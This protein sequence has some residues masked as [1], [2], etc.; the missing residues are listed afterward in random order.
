ME[1]HARYMN[2][3]YKI[4]ITHTRPHFSSFQQSQ[5]CYAI[6]RY[7]PQGSYI[8]A[9]SP[10]M[11]AT[12]SS[13]KFQQ[14]HLLPKEMYTTPNWSHLSLHATLKSLPFYPLELMIHHQQN[15]LCLSKTYSLSSCSNNSEDT[16]FS[17]VLLSSWSFLSH[18][19]HRIR[20]RSEIN[21]YTG[22]HCHI[23]SIFVSLSYKKIF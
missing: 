11:S 14:Y 22:P 2:I 18:T 5:P 19:L 12:R 15:L 3:H 8:R 4:G 10:F 13:P 20:P 7:K 1:N 9:L 17:G 6:L 21:G 23:Q 16:A